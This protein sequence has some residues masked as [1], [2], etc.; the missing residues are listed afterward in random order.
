MLNSLAIGAT[1]ASPRIGQRAITDGKYYRTAICDSSV[2]DIRKTDNGTFYAD[3]AVRG[4]ATALGVRYD[5][6]EMM[7]S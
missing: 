6:D 5:K 7:L 1:T 2:I 3:R 4:Y